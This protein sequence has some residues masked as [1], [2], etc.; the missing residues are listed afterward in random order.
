MEQCEK[1]E[2]AIS[3]GI[4]LVAIQALGLKESGKKLEAWYYVAGH[5][6]LKRVQ[7]RI[8]EK[9]QPSC[10][11]TP[12]LLKPQ[13]LGTTPRTEATVEWSWPEYLRQNVCTANKRARELEAFGDHNIILSEERWKDYYLR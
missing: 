9:M 5:E 1:L 11:E 10:W 3:E 12:V 8:L 2:K 6:S 7:W 13:Y 4:T